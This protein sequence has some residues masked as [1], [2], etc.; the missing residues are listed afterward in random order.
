MGLLTSL[1]PAAVKTAFTPVAIIKDVV[2]VAT[3]NDPDNTKKLLTSASKDF[4]RAGDTI[5]GENNDGIF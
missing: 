1:I 4:E 2:D 5:A 3:G